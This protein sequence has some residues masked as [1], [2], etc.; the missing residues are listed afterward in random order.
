MKDSVE[1]RILGN[2]RSLAAD[3]PNVSTQ[4]DGAGILA[5]E[6]TLLQRAPKRA[7]LGN[8]SANGENEFD[9]SS[10]QRLKLLEAL[11]GC[12]STARVTKA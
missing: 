3:R 8:D 6:Q 5:E 7:R 9:A 4:I 2:R 1:E 12:S 11:F 10:S